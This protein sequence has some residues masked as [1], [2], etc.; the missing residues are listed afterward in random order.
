VSNGVSPL[1]V[2]EVD[3]PGPLEYIP[4]SR[5]GG[6]YAYLWPQASAG[7]FYEG[8]YPPV[9]AVETAVPASARVVCTCPPATLVFYDTSGFLR[10]GFAVDR[11]R[12]LGTWMFVTPASRARP[13]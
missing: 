12:L 1:Y 13:E 6:P 3:A 7:G 11:E 2:N 8:S 5:K 9:D 10:G 4:G